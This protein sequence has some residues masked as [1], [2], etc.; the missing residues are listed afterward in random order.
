MQAN[1]A[2]VRFIGPPRSYGTTMYKKRYIIL[3]NTANDASAVGEANYAKT[4]TDGTS[5]HYYVDDIDLIQSLDT[6]YGANH[7]GSTTGNR[8]GISYEFTGTNGKSESWWSS[9]IAWDKA[10]SNM[11]LDCKDYGIQPRLLTIAQMKDG[12]STGFATHDM[13]RQAWGGTTHTDPGDN[14]PVD[15]VI[16][17]VGAAMAGITPEQMLDMYKK[18]NSLYSFVFFGGDFSSG[19][20]VPEQYRLTEPIAGRTRSGNSLVEHLNYLEQ[21]QGGEDGPVVDVKEQVKQALREGTGDA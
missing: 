1:H 8:Y 17:Y 6:R 2:G 21:T 16:A 3:H 14:F 13:A 19:P 15:F 18:V 11:A 9:N 10:I 4:R 12:V 5:S 7:V 20:L